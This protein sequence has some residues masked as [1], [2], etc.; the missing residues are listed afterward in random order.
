MS[1]RTNNAIRIKPV[2]YNNKMEP[3]PSIINGETFSCNKRFI[4][5]CSREIPKDAK[6]YMEVTVT[7]Y[8]AD[9]T[10][11]HIPLY[12]GVHKEP[13]YGTLC[14]DFILGSVYYTFTK[15]FRIFERKQGIV[16]FTEQTVP[17]LGARIPV[18]GTV[19]GIA[20]DLKNNKI[21]L[22]SD[23]KSFYSFS[24]KTFNLN[25]GDD[26]WFFAIYNE[27][28]IP[29]TG[30]VNF[31]RYKFTYPQNDCISLYKYFYD[32]QEKESKPDP[33]IPTVPKYDNYRF[34]D[35]ISNINIKNSIAPISP[36]MHRHP[37]LLHNKT[38]MKHENDT[39]IFYMQKR[40]EA[41]TDMTT[42]TYPIP[43]PNKVY[44]EINVR[45]CTVK[46][47]YFGIPITIGISN[48]INDIS[49]KA[50]VVDLFHKAQTTFWTHSYVNG[51]KT[52]Y[53]IS[54]IYNPS[55]PVQPNTVGILFDLAHNKIDIYTEGTIFMSASIKG[56]DCSHDGDIWYM[57]LRAQNEV[58][59]DTN[60]VE[61]N[62][63]LC[64]TNF[65][66]EVVDFSIDGDVQT[67]YNYWN[68]AIRFWLEEPFPG[69]P[70]KMK[71]VPIKQDY[72]MDFSC[73][74]TVP[75]TADYYNGFTQGLNMLFDTYNVVTDTEKRRNVPK[76]D[77]F[78]FKKIVDEHTAS[79]NT[80]KEYHAD[81]GATM[82]VKNPHYKDYNVINGSVTFARDR[83]YEF[84]ASMEITAANY[85]PYKAQDQIHG[86]INMV[87][88]DF[89]MRILIGKVDLEK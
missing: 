28:E 17:R 6:V 76:I 85:H 14:N 45:N 20:A 86:F 56:I 38:D 65:G 58:F 60:L 61:P 84:D 18:K 71:V 83:Y 64:D 3:D 26:Y 36:D 37:T 2:A 5:F 10:I 30:R 39:N 41:N 47:G 9:K 46:E 40:E 42:L 53:A 89:I 31:G 70:V 59:E 22:Y 1:T 50:F 19:M 67:I 33:V 78:T 75:R 24:P 27:L 87:G 4:V 21:T 88:V 48:R 62:R 7:K 8:I 43:I 34:N 81:T 32:K 69:F 82:V 74:V 79:V 66:E 49:S 51:K 12:L 55:T 25:T 57:F 80:K 54:K 63:L 72:S 77:P 68:D 23:G 15:D 73:A 52:N 16:Q 29:I 35:I 13:S 11:R 44:M